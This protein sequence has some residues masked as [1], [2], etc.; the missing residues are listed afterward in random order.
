MNLEEVKSDTLR[1]GPIAYLGTVSRGGNPY[2]SPVVVNWV[3]DELVAF[4]ATGEAKVA[5]VRANAKLTV[6]FAVGEATGWDSC[7][8][9]GEARVVDTVEG[10]RALW[11]E[12]GYD[13]AA[14]E[15]GGPEADTHVFIVLRPTRAVVLRMYGAKG[16]DTWHA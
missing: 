15:P 2:V 11:G 7:I 3:G 1:Y 8:L 10:R 12:M 16:R 14:F 5:N 4:A 9:W 6:H 13:L